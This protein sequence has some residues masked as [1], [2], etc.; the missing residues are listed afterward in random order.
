MIKPLMEIDCPHCQGEGK[1]EVDLTTRSDWQPETKFVRC[2]ECSGSG[3]VEVPMT[4][5]E[6]LKRGAALGLP[7]AF[8]QHLVLDVNGKICAACLL[9]C[10]GIVMGVE[11]ADNTFTRLTSLFPELWEITWDDHCL[12]YWIGYQSDNDYPYE[13]IIA[14]TA[15]QLEI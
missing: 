15:R 9:G 2:E 8:G 4:L 3:I 11:V 5:L 10:L 7:R 12:G 13:E 1:I 6:A 14:M